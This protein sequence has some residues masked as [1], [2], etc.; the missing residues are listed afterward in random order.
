MTGAQVVVFPELPLTGYEL[1]RSQQLAFDRLDARREPLLALARRDQVT[2]VVGAPVRL[3][4]RL[5]P[6]AAVLAADGG[7]DWYTK[8]HLGAFGPEALADALDWRL[9]PPEGSV[10]APGAHDPPV[11][12]ALGTARVAICADAQRADH[13]AAAAGTSN[14]VPRLSD[15]SNASVAKLARVVTTAPDPKPSLDCS[16]TVG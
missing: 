12:L 10:L 8:R 5:D 16:P 9:P 11:H 4:G 1:A 3:E 15:S 7:L 2:L 13:A 6:G 14:R